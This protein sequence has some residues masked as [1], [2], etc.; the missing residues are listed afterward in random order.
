MSNTSDQDWND[1]AA[2][3][4]SGDKK[5]YALLLRSITPFI[6]KSL[7]PRLSNPEWADDICQEVLISVQKSLNTY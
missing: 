5:S 7:M 4:Q 3:A 2:A 1:L 6:R